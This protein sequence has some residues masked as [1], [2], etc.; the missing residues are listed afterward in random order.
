ME[1]SSIPHRL[2]DFDKEPSL[3]AL[4]EICGSV[5]DQKIYPLCESICKNIPIY[6]CKAS[7]IDSPSVASALQDEWNHILLSGPG[8]FVLKGMYS[9]QS[10]DLVQKVN[11]VFSSIITSETS[12]KSRGD[13]FADAG[14]NDRIW[15]SFGKHCHADPASFIEYYSNPW[16]ALVCDAWLGPAYKITAQVNIVKPGGAAQVA[17]RDYHLGFQSSKACARYPKAIQVASQLLTL[18]GAVAHTDMALDSGPTRLLPFSQLFEPGYVAFRL[19]QFKQYFLE[20][21]VSLPLEKGD[22][23]FFNPAIFHAAGENITSNFERT[24]N[25][26]QISSAFGKPMETVD[27]LPLISRCWK[28]LTQK[29]ADEGMS[30]AVQAIV[31]A[32]TEGYPFPTNL[33][34]RSPAPA[35][36]APESERD[37]VFRG[38]EEAWSLE[39][40]MRVL[41]Q[42]EADS[43]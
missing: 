23:I 43:A 33:D 2:F 7:Y 27:T 18:Q 25:L 14:S 42:I 6:K 22:G 8:V 32:I 5:I 37:I 4:E 31:V 36:M 15:N 26:L 35:G 13:H 16:L 24:A 1:R 29:Y 39:A 20:K 9:D 34:N 28:G 17:H 21:Y 30:N 12:S 41:E 3:L 11:K 38:L 10:G 40:V 19:P